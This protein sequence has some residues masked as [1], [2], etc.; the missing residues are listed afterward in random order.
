MGKLRIRM[1][2]GEMDGVVAEEMGKR[3]GKAV[4]ARRMGMATITMCASQYQTVESH[5]AL[6]KIGRELERELES[7][8]GVLLKGHMTSGELQEQWRDIL[9][10]H[11]DG[12]LNAYEAWY[13]EEV[14]VAEV[15][16]KEVEDE[17]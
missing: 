15:K 10:R 8:G 14:K 3:A 4:Y 2:N 1:E 9:E 11:V 5:E 6:E 17:N 7:M 12:D 16:R 13:T